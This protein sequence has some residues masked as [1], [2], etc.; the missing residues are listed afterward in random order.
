MCVK[1][2]A[3]KPVMLHRDKINIKRPVMKKRMAEAEEKQEEVPDA[4]NGRME[5]AAT[6]NN[7]F[8]GSLMKA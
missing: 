8:C 2:I 7:F 3:P 6:I 1:T 4:R 5:K